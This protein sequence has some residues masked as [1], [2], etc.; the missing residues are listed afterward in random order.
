MLV[1]LKATL[2][3]YPL[4]GFFALAGAAY[5]VFVGLVAAASPMAVVV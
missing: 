4:A 3:R 5:V 2:A 1:K